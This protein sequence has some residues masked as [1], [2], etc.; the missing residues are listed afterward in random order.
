[1]TEKHN[2]SYVWNLEEM[3]TTPAL[4]IDRASS[5][6]SLKPMI[7]AEHTQ[8][9]CHFGLVRNVFPSL[10]ENIN[11]ANADCTEPNRN[12]H[13]RQIVAWKNQR[14]IR[15]T[16]VEMFWW[17][18][19]VW[20]DKRVWFTKV[21]NRNTREQWHRFGIKHVSR[22]FASSS[23]VRAEFLFYQS[24]NSSQDSNSLCL[25][26]RH[27]ALRESKRSSFYKTIRMMHKPT[28][29]SH[30]FSTLLKDI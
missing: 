2:E 3:T 16:P 11:R 9:F 13:H 30:C 19:L 14:C 7:P 20:H 21:R 6:L 25:F 10:R 15:T 8:T 17:C 29:V 24:T 27:S 26:V 4:Y 5:S 12:S 1:M 28:E 23:A 22:W 18:F